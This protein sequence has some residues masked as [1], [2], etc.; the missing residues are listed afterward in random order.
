MANSLKNSWH[1][2]NIVE[3]AEARKL[4]TPR[5]LKEAVGVEPL[6]LQL[7]DLKHNSCCYCYGEPNAYTYC[8]QP[9]DTKPYC[10]PHR[11]LVYW[12]IR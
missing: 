6:H 3:R 9:V 5:P 8:G 11:K 7:D 10:D 4:P 2:K 12:P 1:P